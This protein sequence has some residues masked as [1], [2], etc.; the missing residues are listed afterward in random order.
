MNSMPGILKFSVYWP[1]LVTTPIPW[2]RATSVPTTLN[3]AGIAA[4]C[5][6]LSAARAAPGSLCPCTAMTEDTISDC[7]ATSSCQVGSCASR[8]RRG[9]SDGDRSRQVRDLLAAHLSG[10]GLDGGED[11][12][13]RAASAD[14][15]GEAFGDLHI[16][17]L[18]DRGEQRDGRHNEAA[19]A[20]ATLEAA[21]EP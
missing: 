9:H 19:R 4:C 10:G 1:R 15:S 14:V 17:R 3:A 13:V 5:V 18:R 8:C 12:L 6:A 16:G 11:L 2:T 21:V 7:S 20:D